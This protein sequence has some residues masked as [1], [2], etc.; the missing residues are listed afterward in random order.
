MSAPLAPFFWCFDPHGFAFLW[1]RMKEAKSVF[2]PSLSM[3]LRTGFVFL[4]VG[5][6][7]FAPVYLK[8][9]TEPAPHDVPLRF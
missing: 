4:R 9:E 5:C 8:L 6:F 3:Y 7:L 2:T 1:A